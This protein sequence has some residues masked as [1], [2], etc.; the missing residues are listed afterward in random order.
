MPEGMRFND[1]LLRAPK[2]YI[3]PN[4]KSKH[5][6]NLY[7]ICLQN[8]KIISKITP[9]NMTHTALT[10]KGSHLIYINYNNFEIL[11]L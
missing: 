3:S 7:M 10:Q 8:Y 6:S 5:G 4:F 1:L 9:E 11:D 2:N